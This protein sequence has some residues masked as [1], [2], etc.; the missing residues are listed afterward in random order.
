[1]AF[2]LADAAAEHGWCATAAHNAPVAVGTLTAVLARV[3]TDHGQDDEVLMPIGDDRAQQRQANEA[4]RVS[5]ILRA[6]AERAGRHD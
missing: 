1:M 4:V 5:A 2:E 3:D 6:R